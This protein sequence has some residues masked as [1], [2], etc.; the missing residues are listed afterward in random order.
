MNPIILIETLVRIRT[1]DIV[2]IHFFKTPQ[3]QTPEIVFV[4]WWLVCN[5]NIW[6]ILLILTQIYVWLIVMWL[7]G[8]N[9]VRFTLNYL[10]RA[11]L[12][13]NMEKNRLVLGCHCC[14]SRTCGSDTVVLMNTWFVI[15][16]GGVILLAEKC[17]P[18]AYVGSMW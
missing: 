16:R 3:F 5:I 1:F 18:F 15:G 10:S 17:P 12:T 4:A 13:W 8:K 2:Q 7:S 11:L 14:A 9:K 6:N